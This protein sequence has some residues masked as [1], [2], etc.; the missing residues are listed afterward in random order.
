MDKEGIAYD[1]KMHPLGKLL[2]RCI[3]HYILLAQERGIKIKLLIESSCYK[4][5]LFDWNQIEVV[6]NNLLDNAVKYSHYGHIVHVRARLD[7][8]SNKYVVQFNSFGVGI[9][10]E[11][12]E[13]IFNKFHRGII[14]KDPRRFIPGTGIGLTVARR[15]A[16]DHEGDVRLV[17]CK[18]GPS[19][20]GRGYKEEGW[21]V[22]FELTLPFKQENGRKNNE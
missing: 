13:A 22:V 19:E 1:M 21:K 9:A 15:I 18:Q 12:R 11:E 10:H 2:E 4:R 17:K 8:A 7:E 3:D 5:S 20:L 16:R 14:M 6:V